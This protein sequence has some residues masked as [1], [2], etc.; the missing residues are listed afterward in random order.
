MDVLIVVLIVALPVLI[1]VGLA[2]SA[3]L[4]GPATSASSRK[5]A[6]AVP[7][8]IPDEYSYEQRMEERRSSDPAKPRPEGL[9]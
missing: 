7:E 6:G 1:L 4:R 9:E 3:S 2:W 8:E 5:D